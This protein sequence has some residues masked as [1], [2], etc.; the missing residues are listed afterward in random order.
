MNHHSIKLECL[1]LCMEFGS[2]RDREDPVKGAEPLYNF[3][4]DDKVK[5]PSKSKGGRPP[6]KR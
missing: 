1:R 2:R 6:K 4:V 5:A 3:V